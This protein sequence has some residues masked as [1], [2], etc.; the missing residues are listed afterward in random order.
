MFVPRIRAVRDPVS[1]W[2]D[3]SGHT[4]TGCG[5]A[6]PGLALGHG[7]SRARWPTRRAIQTQSVARA[8]G[9]KRVTG[10]QFGPRSGVLS[11]RARGRGD[12][13]AGGGAGNASSR[14]RRPG[15][16]WDSR[17]PPGGTT[18]PDGA[19]GPGPS[20]GRA[21]CEGTV[22]GHVTQ[23]PRAASSKGLL[24]PGRQEVLGCCSSAH[25]AEKGVDWGVGDTDGQVRMFGM[26][27]G[28]R[29]TEKKKEEEMPPSQ[30]CAKQNLRSIFNGV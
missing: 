7:L 1:Q 27:K 24:S 21:V 15:C 25:G 30:S 4:R 16:S 22:G 3:A 23:G 6:R 10:G 29:E 20:G 11:P 19:R 9:P 13:E 2:A 5:L 18:A 8:G 17:P 14:T 28:I 26:L 12:A